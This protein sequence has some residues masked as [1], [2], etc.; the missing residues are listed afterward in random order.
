MIRA[1]LLISVLLPSLIVG[2]N[3]NFLHSAGSTAND[4]A[5]DVVQAPNG[6][7]YTTGYFSQTVLFD[8]ITFSHTGNGDGFVA[9]Q[10][11]NGQYLWVVKIDGLLADRGSAIAC[12][13]AG[14]VYA[15]GT[16][17]DNA[18]IG[19]FDV[20]ANNASQDVYV[21]KINPDGAVLW[22]KTFGGQ[23]LENVTGIAVA[24]SGHI[25]LT[26]QFRGTAY[27]GQDTLTSEILLGTSVS[28]YDIY[29]LKLNA[30]GNTVFV[31]KAASNF[32]D[33]STGLQVDNAGNPYLSGHFS[34]D[35]QFGNLT[36]TNNA[37]N[38]G[39]VMKCDS[40]G[41]PLWF[42]KLNAFFLDINGL[43]VRENTLVVGGDF[44]GSFSISGPPVTSFT[45]TSVH[46]IFC[47]RMQLNGTVVN[48]VN[49]GSENSF[50]LRDL[51]LT[52]DNSLLFTGN[53]SCT[54]TEYSAATGEGLFNSIG[55]KDV[56]LS[57]YAANGSRQWMRQF[58]GP[59][60]DEAHAICINNQ[61]S[62]I[63]V[64]SYEAQFQIPLTN[65]FFSTSVNQ[66]ISYY[67]HP[68]FPIT[69]CSDNLYGKFVGVK[70]FGN[71]DILS[72]SAY[73]ST[74]STYDY[75]ERVSGACVFPIVPPRI[76]NTEDTI[77][78][79]D[80]AD[81]YVEL[82]TGPDSL[83]GPNYIF[84]WNDGETGQ[85]RNISVS[86]LYIV[87]IA[88][89]DGCQ[90][91]QDSIYI[92]IFENP[93]TPNISSPYG[94]IKE[95]IPPLGCFDKLTKFATDTALL[96]A[97]PL[98]PGETGQWIT[99]LGTTVPGNQFNAFFPGVYTYQ[100][101][102][103]FGCTKYICVSLFNYIIQNSN[104]CGPD[105]DNI[106][107]QFDIFVNGTLEDTVEICYGEVI[108]L[109]F[110][111]VQEFNQLANY[112]VPAFALWEISNNATFA[113]VAN[114][115]GP[116]TFLY[117][118][119]KVNQPNSGFLDITVTLLQPPFNVT[120][121]YTYSR[122]VYIQ[123]NPL[124]EFD[125]EL[126]C[127][128]N[129]LCPGDTATVFINS[130]KPFSI[131][132]NF[133]SI[134]SDS[135]AIY[136]VQPGYINLSATVTDP[137]TGCVKEKTTSY[138]LKYKTAPEVIMNPSS[139][140]KCP[141]DSVSLLAESA[142]IIEW[143]GPQG[144]VVGVSA[145]IEVNPPGN[146]YYIQTDA[147][148]CVL[149]S[150]TVEVRDLSTPQ[151]NTS[152]GSICYG[153][154]AQIS[155]SAD[156]GVSYNWLPPLSGS[157]TI[158]LVYQPGIYTVEASF[159]NVMLPINITVENSTLQAQISFVYDSVLCTE[160]NILLEA[161][162]S[163]Q[164]YTW[165]P[166]AIETQQFYATDSGWVHLTIKD[167]DGCVSKDSIYLQEFTSPP[168]PD[169]VYTSA[170]C[171]GSLATAIA[172]SSWPIAWYQNP[173][174]EI[175]AINDSTQIL[176]IELGEF[177]YA[178]NLDTSNGCPS[179]RVP[180]D[181]LLLNVAQTPTFPDSI[182]ACLGSNISFIAGSFDGINTGF[183]SGPNSFLSTSDSLQIDTISAI[184]QGI[185]SYNTVPL[186]GFCSIDTAS[187]I[188]SI[189]TVPEPVVSYT[190]S[191]CEN[192]LLVLSPVENPA[193]NYSWTGPNNFNTPASIV[194]VNN[195]SEEAEGY[196]S[197]TS[198]AFGCT[199]TDSFLVDVL[200]GPPSTLDLGF[201]SGHCEGDTIFLFNND[202]TLSPD[203]QFV[204]INTQ[205]FITLS[206]DTVYLPNAQTTDTDFYG[207]QL[208]LGT[209]LSLVEYTSIVVGAIPVFIFD[210]VYHFC[211]GD[212]LQL[213]SPIVAQQ[214]L[215]SNGETT[216]TISIQFDDTLTLEVVSAQ[217]CRFAD[218]T[219]VD[220]LYCEVDRTP[221]T[222]SPNGDGI[223]D[224]LVFT[225]E[226][227]I[228]HRAVIF[229][230]WGK[231]VKELIGAEAAWD[232][233]N[234]LG[235][236][237]TNGTYFYV[238]NVGMLNGEQ[239]ALQ[240]TITVFD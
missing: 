41:N 229:D 223:N 219:I 119:N 89:A 51:T 47:I 1:L 16:F 240:G 210:S 205:G 5:L 147:N 212:I 71:K 116:Y 194:Q 114:G 77:S 38:A 26:G 168:P 140:I 167:Q 121:F 98:L 125:L 230:R 192:S 22:V 70:S 239:Q 180:L 182:T 30:A 19:G 158:Q 156:A 27:F 81:V 69:Y 155:V 92:Q 90:T 124:P 101:T 218:T 96:V 68:N 95:A 178:A 78:A 52:Q 217:G 148:N 11:P 206:N 62:P 149:L 150:N 113:G 91:Y 198:T 73:S 15:T 141:P 60:E 74:R 175:I 44:K 152:P 129:G 42:K 135:T 40:A 215:W 157:D 36:Y 6:N 214:Y 55:F 189:T 8:N 233:T 33:R 232:G 57:S 193:V 136:A 177:I 20:T 128:T 237:I 144:N 118:L 99:P 86:G 79:C 24:P 104:I 34:N 2:Q 13:N 216:Q 102:N 176:V 208:Q 58:G 161:N 28:S 201:S 133:I 29:L 154:P 181:L 163:M 45:S 160:R 220:A 100:L 76:G 75:Y 35:L 159:C 234:Q 199:R 110:T 61:V 162:D 126:V 170:V 122:T 139:G 227:G 151:I 211:E 67:D 21:T 56:Y 173:D 111:D 145:Q 17:T 12:D 235:A 39:F 236:K 93:T 112:N 127:P 18:E 63:I 105:C 179:A 228:I 197:L 131:S 209:C 53:F 37:L 186:E 88:T 224:K 49:E 3:N 204:W 66:S 203:I 174:E 115:G 10:N 191:I 188:L 72:T 94:E 132:G 187:I 207:F 80:Y 117:H 172:L 107:P 97:D 82:G 137:I 231:L 165:S 134:N 50:D 25:W 43:H 200:P 130:P 202:S 238:L 171:P 226:G 7:I 85:N 213:E 195:I 184:N 83:V 146:Y 9:C 221:N 196:Y 120:S 166:N 143:I 225:V 169:S 153:E 23:D 190:D 48:Y 4:E 32:N 14:N 54:Q 84:T 31:K 222:F 109:E 65:Q 106:I 103:Q 138:L 183:W 142:A 123:V 185:Y 59:A 164:L 87:T 108:D 64:G 46:N